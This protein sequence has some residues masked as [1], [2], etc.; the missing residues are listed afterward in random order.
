MMNAILS[1]ALMT[2]I[3]FA[4]T[5]SMSFPR[6]SGLLIDTALA[7]GNGQS[8]APLDNSNMGWSLYLKLMIL[9]S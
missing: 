6:T 7:T 9:L 5:V 1:D 2:T 4:L 3:P 8:R